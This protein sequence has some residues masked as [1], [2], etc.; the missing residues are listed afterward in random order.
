M[1]DLVGYLQTEK[2]T[3]SR[4]EKRL[5]ELILSDVEQALG[6]S[7]VD[8]AASAAVSPPTV[9]RFCRR[10]GCDSFSEF[11]VRLAQSRFVGQR[12]LQPAG[13]PRAVREI[14]QA[15]VNHAQSN[16]Y[17][18]FDRIDVEQVERAAVLLSEA[19]YVLAFGSGGGSSMIANEIENRLFRLGLKVTGCIDHQAQLMRAAGAPRG[20]VIVA[21]SFSGNNLPLARALAIAGE[22]GVQR[23]VLARSGSQVAREADILLAMDM[24]ED[25]DILRPTSSRYAYLAMVDVLAQ[26]TATRIEADAVAS[27]R[28]I[29]HQLIVNRDSDD[30]QALGD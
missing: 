25:S 24:P 14:A 1:L 21:S 19:R 13:G 5:A 28:R 27:M 7:I 6:A 2:D 10:I 15:V 16:L 18:F 23:V 4:S 11:K 26:T 9:T 20:T 12:Y 30:S 3:F 8:L 17:T 29:K 22:Y